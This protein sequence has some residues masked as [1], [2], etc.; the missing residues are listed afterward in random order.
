MYA[1]A[2]ATAGSWSPWNG[3]D[4]RLVKGMVRN[5]HQ[6]CRAVTLNVELDAPECGDLDVE[7]EALLV[8]NSEAMIGDHDLCRCDRD[9]SL[10]ALAW[11]H[12]SGNWMFRIERFSHVKP[13]IWR[14]AQAKGWLRPR[15]TGKVNRY[16]FIPTFSSAGWDQRSAGRRRRSDRGR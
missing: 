7:R 16:R 11:A 12:P 1:K 8:R 13:P 6:S 2:S 10:D 5:D 15:I 3:Q 14:V 9:V 4:L